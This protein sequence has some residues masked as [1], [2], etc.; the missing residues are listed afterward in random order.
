MADSISRRTFLE[1]AAVTGAAASLAGV[2]RAGAEESTSSKKASSVSDT[3][4][5]GVMGTNGRGTTLARGFAQIEGC[6]VGKVCDVDERN[7]ARAV[8]AVGAHQSKEP[9]G[10]VDFRRILDDPNI[11]ALVIAA[12]DHWHGPATIFGCQ[13]GKHVY[14]EKPCSHNPAE[15]EM[16][17]AAAR[18]HDRVVTMGTQRRSWPWIADA[19]EQLREG[20]IGPVRYAKAW[21][22]NR[23]GPIG[24]G[25]QTAAP[26]WLDWSLWQGP[27]PEQAYQDNVVHYNWHWFWH[28]GTGELGNN[29]VHILDLCRWGLGVDFPEKVTSTGGRYCYDD[30]QQTPDTH[31]VTYQFGD[32]A[33]MWQG[34]SCQVHGFEGTRFG[35]TFHGDDGTLVLLDNGVTIYDKMDKQVG[36]IEATERGDRPHLTNFLQSIR[37]GKR[38]NADIEKAHRSTLLCQLGNIA[39]RVGRSLAIDQATGHI[40]DDDDASKLWSRDYQK[41]WEP[42]V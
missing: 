21:Y 25:K 10:V 41:G 40:V 36:T 15:G 9:E 24:H 7:L 34:L 28:W 38:P 5:I 11:D 37:D 14:V 29:G 18:K 8:E 4:T 23:R 1:R 32:K 27:A 3:I 13:A 30:D 17:L 31:V 42:K 16:M 39:H 12:P 2:G 20:V 19:F 6:E 35:A 33:L 26:E 22:N